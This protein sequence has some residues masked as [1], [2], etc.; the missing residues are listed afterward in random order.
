[1]TNNQSQVLTGRNQQQDSTN[2]IQIYGSFKRISGSSSCGGLIR[3]EFGNFVK[4][5]Y[6]KPSPCN[7]LM[8]E[9][10]GLL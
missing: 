5:Y 2:A 1:M 8:A 4:G 3:D 6:C 7:A 10:N 9:L